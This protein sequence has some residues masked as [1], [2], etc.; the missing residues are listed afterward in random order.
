[1]FKLEKNDEQN[2]TI[3]K[4]NKQKYGEVHTPY[5]FIRHM[6]KHLPEEVLTNSELNWLDP[7]AGRGYFA[8]VLVKMLSSYI[9]LNKNNKISISEEDIKLN[10][11]KRV[12]NIEVN[13][14]HKKY[15][16]EVSCVEQIWYGN[17]MHYKGVKGWPEQFDVIVGNPP[18]NVSGL[19]K[20][21]TNIHTS[22]INDGITI[23]PEFVFKSIELLK[24][25]GHLCM[26]IP[27]IWLKPDIYGVHSLLLSPKIKFHYLQ[28]FN[29]TETNRIFSGNAQ[30]PTTLIVVQKRIVDKKNEDTSHYVLE[31]NKVLMYDNYLGTTF[32]YSH[33]TCEPLPTHSPSLV[34]RMVEWTRI[35]GQLPIIKTSLANKEK[36]QYVNVDGKDKPKTYRGV[37][38]CVFRKGN[39]KI[40][41]FT[42]EERQTP[43]PYQGEKKIIMAHKM[44]GIPYYDISGEYGISNRD[45]Y[46]ILKSRLRENKEE[47]MYILTNFLA[48]SLALFLFDTTRYRMRYLEKYAFQFIPDIVAMILDKKLP[49]DIDTYLDDKKICSLFGYKE[50][51]IEYI[52]TNYPRYAKLET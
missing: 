9:S 41:K 35:Y 25:G 17:Y 33:Q 46:I 1:M 29:N 52:V 44:Y 37:R 5:S 26:I 24:P 42:I 32:L 48:S 12:F 36:H 39:H 23:W 8:K 45:N 20:V 22:K 13:M 50:D 34:Y 40:P 28:C 4:N 6:L 47:M 14:E 18:Y 2:I 51:E 27:S 3:Y 11:S 15:L 21:P 43:Y 38:S 30:T 31:Y 19:K 7:C 16:E 49:D 10:V